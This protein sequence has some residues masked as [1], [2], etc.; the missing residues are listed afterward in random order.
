MWRR[1]YSQTLLKNQNGAC[2]WINNLKS[3]IQFVFTACQVEDYISKY[4]ETNLPTTFSCYF[5]LAD[6]VSLP[7]YLYYER[8]WAVC[9]L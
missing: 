7:G 3:S 4:I 1:N 5:L 6:Q 2:F 8:Y 9:V